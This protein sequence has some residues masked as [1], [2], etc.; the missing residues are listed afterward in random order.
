[1]GL[2]G[3]YCTGGYVYDDGVILY[4]DHSTLA[5]KKLGEGYVFDY[6]LPLDIAG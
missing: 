3:F 6:H 1:M 4:S 2:R 5:L